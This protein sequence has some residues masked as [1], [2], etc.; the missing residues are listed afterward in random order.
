[1]VRGK[2]L[3]VISAAGGP[4]L[5]TPMDYMTPFINTIFGF[6]GFNDIKH[7]AINES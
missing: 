2:P 1:M 7:I 6:I 3:L 4:T 5:N